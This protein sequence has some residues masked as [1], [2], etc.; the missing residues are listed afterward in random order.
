MDAV[1]GKTKLSIIIIAGNEEAV[2]SDCLKSALFADEI[3]FIAA[4]STDNTVNLVNK[5]TPT[6]KIYRLSDSYGRH[7]AKWRNLG[8]KHASGDWLFYLDA[9]ERI[10]PALRRQIQQ[11]INHPQFNH[12]AIPRANHFLGH[13]VNHGGTYPDYVKRLFQ[14]CHLNKWTGQIHE[15]PIISGQIGYLSQDLLHFTH[16]QLTSMLQKSILWTDVQAQTIHQ[17]QHPPIVA[18]RILRMMFTKF[19]QR[20]FLQSMWRDGTIGF[21]SLI[22]ETFDTYMIYARLWEIQQTKN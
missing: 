21:I 8:L 7:F 5:I 10:T 9:D 19:Y 15:E 11:T 12:Y 6:A 13:R 22:F 4:N 3:I 20:F 16:R 14:R 18:W 1:A 2:I 17:H